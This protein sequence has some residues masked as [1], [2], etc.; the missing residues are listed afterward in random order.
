M[1]FEGRPIKMNKI[2]LFGASELGK[3]AL[4]R[5][6]TENIICFVDNN[7]NKIGKK[8]CGKD[9]ISVTKMKN[10]YI[11]S[12][13]I[14]CINNSQAKMS[15]YNQLKLLGIE[16][17]DFYYRERVISYAQDNE[18]IILY[19]VL[20]DINDIF[21][22]DVGAN[23]PLFISVTKLLYDY[24]NARGI[25]IEPQLDLIKILQ[26]E[27]NRD[28]NLCVALGDKEM[29]A[30]LNISSCIGSEWGRGELSSISRKINEK[31]TTIDIPVK[32]LKSI[33]KEYVNSDIH[34]LKIDVEGYEKNVFLGGDF[35][36]YRPWI[37]VIEGNNTVLYDKDKVEFL[38][39][40]WESLILDNNYTFVKQCGLNRYYLAS[41]K[42]FLKERFLSIKELNDI[43][44]IYPFFN[45]Y[46]LWKLSKKF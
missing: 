44:E 4:V 3:T 11:D 41:E 1:Y 8:Y 19:H 2:V 46:S 5:Y 21:Y 6:G 14:I 25:N 36:K 18:D 32:T 16:N 45:M 9:I 22:I 17:V 23:D 31:D 43:Y 27:R 24:K 30:Q 7:I 35:T 39:V 37:I 34:I 28:V 33:C 13:V 26:Q 38:D 20:K 10:N 40:E 12:K 42:S 29:N 15:V